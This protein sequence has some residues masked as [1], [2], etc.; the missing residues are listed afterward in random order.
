M[1][2]PMH[3]TASRQW[4]IELPKIRY[5]DKIRIPVATSVVDELKLAK[6]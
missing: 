5:T 2:P 1:R 4:L 6:I 3:D